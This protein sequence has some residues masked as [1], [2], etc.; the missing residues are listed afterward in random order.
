MEKIERTTPD[1]TQE[2]VDR[3]AELFPSVVTEA[4]DEKG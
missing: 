1:L 2:N 3:L 4:L